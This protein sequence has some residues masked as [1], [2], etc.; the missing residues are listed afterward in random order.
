VNKDF[1]G[2]LEKE[3]NG[4]IDIVESLDRLPTPSIDK[5]KLGRRD[6]YINDKALLKQYREV[7][8]EIKKKVSSL[9]EGLNSIKDFEWGRVNIALFGETNSGKSTLIEA[10]IGGSGETIGDGRKDYTRSVNVYN[11]L[12]EINFLDVPGI[13]GDEKEVKSEIWKALE[14]AHLV[15]YVY[16][17]TKEPERG[18]LEKIR[19]YLRK[20][21]EIYTVIN[22]RGIVPPHLLQKKLE[23]SQLVRKRTDEHLRTTLGEIYKGSFQVHALFAFFSRAK[24]I[25]DNEL[26]G[27]CNTSLKLYGSKEELRRVSGIDELLSFFESLTKNKNVY[28]LKILWGNFRKILATQEEII[29][30]ILKFKKDYDKHIRLLNSELKE[31]QDKFKREKQVLEINIKK[32]IKVKIEN[33]SAKLKKSIHSSIDNEIDPKTLEKQ[34]NQQLLDFKHQLKQSLEQEMEDFKDKILRDLDVLRKKV[35]FMIAFEVGTDLKS[36]IDKLS[37]SF[38]EVLKEIGDSLLSV[39]STI[40][41]FFINPILGII[42]GLVSLVRKLWDWFSGNVKKKKADAKKKANEQVEKTINEIRKEIYS[43]LDEIYREIERQFEEIVAQVKGIEAN[44][45]KTSKLLDPIIAKLLEINV[46][47]S[48]LFIKQIDPDAKFAYIQTSL[49]EGTHLAVV[50]PNYYDLKLKL[51]LLGI[52]NIFIFSSMDELRREI[53]STSK[54]KEFFIRLE[55]I[56]K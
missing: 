20:N 43:K 26:L 15:L 47:T 37:Y 2:L 3:I 45:R 48:I 17:D 16:P 6:K 9:V 36:V 12:E 55:R 53:T 49:R 29:G 41:L 25:L 14:K 28:Q 23:N 32:I 50:T 52:N 40:G 56:L 11:F 46:Y 33:L 5:S 10:I 30:K 39:I 1:L 31:V 42:A 7:V 27:K 54:R 21:A 13:E 34:V 4:F 35:E 24:D 38:W 51:T 8:G 22:I 19:K 18:T 44:F